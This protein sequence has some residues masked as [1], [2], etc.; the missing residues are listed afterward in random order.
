MTSFYK[1]LTGLD[2]LKIGFVNP[3]V[4][5]EAL[6]QGL[7][8]HNLASV[9]IF[10][11]LDSTSPDWEDR[12]KPQLFDEALF[13]ESND[14]N[15]A[16][17]QIRSQKL[18]YLFYGCD[19]TEKTDQLAQVVCPQFAN[20]PSTSAYRYDKSQFNKVLEEKNILTPKTLAINA[21]YLTPQD[22]EK[23]KHWHF[24]V[25]LKPA[26]SFGMIGFVEC[27][28][29]SEI[30]KNLSNKIERN[31][32]SN[33]DSYVIQEKLIGDLYAIDTFS[34]QGNHHLVHL[35]VYEKSYLNGTPVSRQAR[36]LFPHDTISKKLFHYIQNV[37][38]AIELNNGFC[39]TE[40]FVT[41]SGMFT[42]DINPRIPGGNNSA[43]SLAIETYGLDHIDVMC[44][45]LL[46]QNL[47]PPRYRNGT[48]AYLHNHVTR[49]IGEINQT[50]MK[51][52]ASFKH[53]WNN[54]KAGSMV[55]TPKTL[56]DTVA[57][58]VLAHDDQPQLDQD[59]K[60]LLSMEKNQELF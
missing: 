59:Y 5:P 41:S 60:T 28:N 32:I 17:N 44:H 18:D 42:I 11:D 46:K 43:C 7:K 55:S 16:I 57:Y 47:P 26:N 13:L 4:S 52:L 56:G 38:T 33:I 53:C 35:R 19:K 14:L 12:I 15:S 2:M 21:N 10:T 3:I 29:I 51:N 36:S 34:L 23:L 30:E 31:L 20:N 22:K 50:K 39:H 48:I 1:D 45:T 6:T 27:Q 40:V 24:P 9:A 25:I 37:L 58:V 8:R 54:K 49:K